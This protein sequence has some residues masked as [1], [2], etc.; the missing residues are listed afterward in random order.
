MKPDIEIISHC[1]N[2][3]RLLCYQLSS[4]LLDPP[5]CRVLMDVCMTA[6]DTKTVKMAEWFVNSPLRPENVEIKPIMFP[7]EMLLRRA[8]GRNVL[9]LVTEAHLV[10][11]ADCDMPFGKG[12][13][14]AMLEG[15]KMDEIMCYPRHVMKCSHE[16]GDELIARV[17]DTK[18]AAID[19]ES[20]L[21]ARQNR[22]IGGIQ[23]VKG[24]TARRWGYLKD[25]KRYQK[26][27]K[28]WTRTKEDPVYRKRV[29]ASAGYPLQIQNVFRIRHSK[30][31]REHVGVE[32]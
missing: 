28:N 5:E 30:Y 19:V 29:A 2:Y 6:E 31:G 24:E 25:S 27:A 16:H 12:S 17:T 21:P 7:R 22:A 26:P 15:F 18:L 13:L 11:F 23:V 9:A 10:W 20:F 1:W 3:S 8:I 4:L 32:N 14:D